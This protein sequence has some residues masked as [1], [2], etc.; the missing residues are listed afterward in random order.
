MHRVSSALCHVDEPEES[1]TLSYPEL[2]R[3]PLDPTGFQWVNEQNEKLLD[4]VQVGFHAKGRKEGGNGVINA[5]FSVKMNNEQFFGLR[6]RVVFVKT[7][8]STSVHSS[9]SCS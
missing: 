3:D 2:L 4:L 7:D 6:L 9:N 8:T 1:E 5:V